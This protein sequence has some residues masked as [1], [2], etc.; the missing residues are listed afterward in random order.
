MKEK[1][2]TPRTRP[3]RV[4]II[5]D[6]VGDADLVRE[7]FDEGHTAVVIDVVSD[8]QR[9][10]DFLERREPFADAERPDL[11]LLDLNLPKRSG[12]EVL[13]DIR[14]CEQ[15]RRL[16]VIVFTSSSADRDISESYRLG[17]NCYIIKPIDF[18]A[19]RATVSYID[20]FWFGVVC[21]P[22]G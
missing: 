9:V 16:P 17:A 18:S 5:E 15:F 6:N 4:L 12:R 10:M 11:V 3:R 8:G 20:S 21:L 1:E 7:A 19:L 22:A 13:A 14:A 2:P